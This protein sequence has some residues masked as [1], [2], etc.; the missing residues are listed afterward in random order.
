MIEIASGAPR[1][2]QA[3]AR[4]ARKVAGTSSSGELQR[5]RHQQLRRDEQRHP[6]QRG[7]QQVQQLAAQRRRRVGRDADDRAD[8]GDRC[9]PATAQRA[10]GEGDEEQPEC[11]G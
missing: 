8:R 7:R 5:M 1:R 2:P 4:K 11:R 10:H 3:P 6:E 9:G